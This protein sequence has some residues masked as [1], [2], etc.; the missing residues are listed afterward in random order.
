ML[1]ASEVQI[2]NEK[3]DYELVQAWSSGRATTKVFL[4]ES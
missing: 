3:F 2:L 1:H 4:S